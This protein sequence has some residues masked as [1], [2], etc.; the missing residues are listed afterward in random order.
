MYYA[1]VYG[2]S[3]NLP[4]AGLQSVRLLPA[5]KQDSQYIRRKQLAIG[6]KSRV[7]L[8]LL[9]SDSLRFPEAPKILFGIIECGIPILSINS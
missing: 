9:L 4:H 3:D 5:L 6:H 1:P 8:P 7:H 2:R